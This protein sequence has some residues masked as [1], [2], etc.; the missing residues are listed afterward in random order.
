[1][2]ISYFFIFNFLN[3]FSSIKNKLITNSDKKYLIKRTSISP[4][5]YMIKSSFIKNINEMHYDPIVEGIII[6]ENI[7]Q[8]TITKNRNYPIL[9]KMEKYNIQEKIS[10]ELNFLFCKNTK[11]YIHIEQLITKTN[12]FHIGISFKNIRESIRYDLAGINIQ[13]LRF[14]NTDKNIIKKTLFWDYTNKTLKEISDYESTLN[15]RYLLGIYDCRHYVR[16]LT[17]WTTNN[18]TPIWNLYKIL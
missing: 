16:E 1:M 9:N 4:L 12:I 15:N 13:Y 2:I 6:D 10:N 11:V 8:K 5:K 7:L 14:A 17:N 3:I 18:P